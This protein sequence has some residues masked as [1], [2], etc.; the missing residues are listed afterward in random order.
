MLQRISEQCVPHQNFLCLSQDHWSVNTLMGCLWVT[1]CRH[2]DLW[3]LAWSRGKT[4]DL[5]E[6][7]VP[8]FQETFPGEGFWP[9]SFDC[10]WVSVATNERPAFCHSTLQDSQANPEVKEVLLM[11]TKDNVE[12]LKN[13]SSPQSKIS[14]ARHGSTLPSIPELRRQ[15][16]VDPC[17][18]EA[19]LVYIMSSNTARAIERHCFKNL[20][21]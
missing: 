16:L 8:S 17:E 2:T 19:N 1:W 6:Q 10:K 14:G 4:K 20:S 12:T 3:G 21:I 9:W 18:F 15:R 7:M 5:K 13:S 11:D